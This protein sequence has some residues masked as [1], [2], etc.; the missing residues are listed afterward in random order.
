MSNFI[1]YIRITDVDYI[2]KLVIYNQIKFGKRTEGLFIFI[3]VL[4]NP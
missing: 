1:K 3:I 4:E 2:A